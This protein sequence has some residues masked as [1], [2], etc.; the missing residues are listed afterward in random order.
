LNQQGVT[1]IVITHDAAIGNRATRKIR[2]VDG[3]IV[4]PAAAA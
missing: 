3:N 2:I 4:V 1:L